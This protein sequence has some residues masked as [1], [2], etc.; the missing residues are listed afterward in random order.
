MPESVFVANRGEIALRIVR[1]ARE[2]GLDVVVAV[3]R[4][5]VDSLAARVATGVHILPGEGAGAYLD[6]ESLVAG[7]AE[8]GCTLLHP[9]YGF[10]SESP[11]LARACAAAGVTFVG[12]DA[13]LLELFGDKGSARAAAHE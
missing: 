5:E 3:T 1:A 10:L 8:H 9:G 13:S 6:A 11:V 12:P 2:I 4:A 7:A